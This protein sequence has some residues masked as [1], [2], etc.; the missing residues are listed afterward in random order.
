MYFI[1]KKTVTFPARSAQTSL[2]WKGLF[3]MKSDQ[4]QLVLLCYEP[5]GAFTS[6]K[7][8]V[9]CLLSIV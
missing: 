5:E 6:T 8:I 2:K 1:K 9:N 3:D 4:P 7:K